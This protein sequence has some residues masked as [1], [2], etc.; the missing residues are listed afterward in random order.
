M[1]RLVPDASVILKWVLPAEQETH[2]QRALDLLCAFEREEIE[3]LVPTLWL[4]EIG[5]T[6]TRKSPDQA[7][8]ILADLRDLGM[9]EVSDDDIFI[10]EAIRLTDRYGVTFY[11]AVYHAVAL[12]RQATLVSADRRYVGAVTPEPQVVSLAHWRSANAR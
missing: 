2:V 4:Y 10:R 12:T 7:E 8:G 3:L 9:E 6:V 1:L 5:N 11:D